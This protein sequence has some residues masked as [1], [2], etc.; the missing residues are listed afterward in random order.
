M[1]QNRTTQRYHEVCWHYKPIFIPNLSA[2]QTKSELGFQIYCHTWLNAKG[3]K[4]GLPLPNKYSHWH[5]SAG[6]NRGSGIYGLRA[7]LMAKRSGQ[8][9]GWPDWVNCHRKIAVELKLPKGTLSDEQQQWL[10][11]FK[12]IGYHAECVRSFERFCELVESV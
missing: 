9:R 3:G 7:G 6:E 8:Q 4:Q 1:V 2:A 5:H 12:H 11:Y 10:A